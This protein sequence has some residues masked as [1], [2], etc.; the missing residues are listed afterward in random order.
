MRWLKKV[1]WVTTVSDAECKACYFRRDEKSRYGF[2]VST[3]IQDVVNYGRPSER[4][5]PAGTGSG[6][7]LAPVQHLAV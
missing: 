3:R 2:V 6:L 1:L 5:L 4:N 7:I